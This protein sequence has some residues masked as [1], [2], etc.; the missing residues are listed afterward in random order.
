MIDIVITWVN[1]TTGYVENPI[2]PDVYGP[3]MYYKPYNQIGLKRAP[4]TEVCWTVRSYMY[5]DMDHL[6]NKIY[7]VYN[8]RRHPPPDCFDL[9]YRST[10]VFISYSVLLQ[11]TILDHPDASAPRPSAV[12]VFMHRIPKLLP[13]FIWTMDDIF[14]TRKFRISDFYD[15]AQQKIKTRM[16]GGVR[17]FNPWQYE[18]NMALTN[19]L[20][21]PSVHSEGLHV[22]SLIERQKSQELEDHFSNTLYSKCYSPIHICEFHVHYITLVLNYMILRGVAINHPPPFNL[23]SEVHTTESMDLRQRLSRPSTWMN[24][25]GVG[26]SDEYQF[27]NVKDAVRLRIEFDEWLSAQPFFNYSPARKQK[28]DF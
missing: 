12:R 5:W 25:Q 27:R 22:P 6:I 8:E 18:S 21:Q 3:P 15:D 14:L 13:Y 19:W 17:N 2:T 28:Y 23:F 11:G 20:G 24:V 16:T 7:I 4:W 26:V 1:Y 9:R 10:V